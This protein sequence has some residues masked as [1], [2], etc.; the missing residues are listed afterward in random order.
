V[1]CLCSRCKPSTTPE[2]YEEARLL[3]R[4]QDGRFKI[5]CQESYEDVS[6]L[7]LLDGLKLA[8][9]PPWA[10][11]AGDGPPTD[12]DGPSFTA[13]SLRAK[14]LKKIRIFLA[15]SSELREDRD[16]FDLYFRQQTD[17]WIEK[18]IYLQIERWE[19]FLDVMSETRKQADYN[20][21]VRS[22]DIFVSLFKTKTGKF[23]EEEFDV[24]HAA[25]QES[26]SPLIYTYFMKSAVSNDRKLRDDLNSLW[27]F[28]DKLSGLGCYHTSYNNIEDLKLQFKDQLEQLVVENRI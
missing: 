10:M 22:C 7:E 2:R 6:V 17:R 23:T 16:A 24:A 26:G 27:A 1:P 5:E 21:K 9:L 20:E 13:G 19:T 12:E 14:P 18:G 25:F 4:K 28:Q 11:D 3:K 15:S 8:T